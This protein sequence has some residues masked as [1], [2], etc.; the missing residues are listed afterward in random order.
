M[1]LTGR[2]L[3]KTSA[4]EGVSLTDGTNGSSR[5]SPMSMLGVRGRSSRLKVKVDEQLGRIRQALH[6]RVDMDTG[7]PLVS[8]LICKSAVCDMT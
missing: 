5:V 4:K 2:K 6:C 7:K 8:F 3:L 1:A